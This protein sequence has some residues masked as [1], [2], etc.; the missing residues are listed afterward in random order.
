M[1][2][3]V[4]DEDKENNIDKMKEK[5]KDLKYMVGEMKGQIDNLTK[6]MEKLT[7]IIEELQS[8]KKQLMDLLQAKNSPRRK[9]SKKSN[10][11]KTTPKTTLLTK[12]TISNAQQNN[13]NGN[14]GERDG[15]MSQET[16]AQA[17][18]TH[19]D[20][21][22]NNSN[23]NPFPNDI[24]MSDDGTQKHNIES[25]LS[26]NEIS[27]GDSSTD[28]DDD[29]DDTKNTNNNEIARNV[30]R[31]HKLPAV[32]IWTSNRADIQKEIQNIVP[33]SKCLYSRVNNTKFR[34]LPCDAATR[35]IVIKY[36][37]EKKY[38]YNTYTPNESKMI[39]VLIKGLD[40]IEEPEVIRT[41]LA[42][43]GFEPYQIKKHITGY[44]RQNGNKSNLWLIKYEQLIKR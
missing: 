12:P 43:K 5:N 15:S 9:K 4:H 1:K 19:T 20:A 13:G 41:E 44:M 26:E 21:L 16:N 32:D 22:V 23:S 40:H 35:D 3:I 27:D 25:K 42:E 17:Q 29:D 24:D 7:N 30:K 18:E 11:Q 39:N 6:Q 31:S 34:V 28:D 33:A 8:E 37:K 14:G 10:E 38:E 36:L 2:V